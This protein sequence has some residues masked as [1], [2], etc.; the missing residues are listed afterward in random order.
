MDK[1]RL[2]VVQYNWSGSLAVYASFASQALE[3]N[4][5]VKGV[6]AAKVPGGGSWLKAAGHARLRI[7]ATCDAQPCLVSLHVA[8]Q[9][10]LEL[11]LMESAVQIAMLPC[12]HTSALLLLPK[13][14]VRAAARHEFES[15]WLLRRMRAFPP[16]TDDNQ[17]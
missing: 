1:A 8:D 17:A 16:V 14:W 5:P 3:L 15:G 7:H 4:Q 12:Q 6:T 9:Q 10:I 13:H 2:F 11:Q